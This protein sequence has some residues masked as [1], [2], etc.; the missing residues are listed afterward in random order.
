MKELKTEI[1]QM[2]NSS[3]SMIDS[4][5]DTMNSGVVVHEAEARCKQVVINEQGDV[6][7]HNKDRIHLRKE[8]HHLIIT[9]AIIIII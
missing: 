4:L 9:H 3:R 1:T 8:S 2:G 6:Q 7:Q 5:A